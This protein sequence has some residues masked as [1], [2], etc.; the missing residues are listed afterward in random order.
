MEFSPS[1]YYI[2]LSV[3][4]RNILSR[5]AIIKALPFIIYGDLVGSFLV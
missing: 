1:K 3:K 5:S 4:S 2:C